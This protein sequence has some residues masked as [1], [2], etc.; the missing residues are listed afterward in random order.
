MTMNQ[1]HEVIQTLTNLT[2]TQQL[3]WKPANPSWDGIPDGWATEVDKY[4]LLI[5]RMPKRLIVSLDGEPSEIVGG[6]EGVLKL[7]RAVAAVWEQDSSDSSFAQARVRELE[8]ALASLRR[9]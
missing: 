2:K 4:R 7:L 1:G 8:A 9:S 6:G 3:R 5:S